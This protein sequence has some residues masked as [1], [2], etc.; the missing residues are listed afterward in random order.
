M[1]GG[2]RLLSR[3]DRGD[4]VIAPDV[5]DL[6]AA[7][8][9]AEI[10]FEAIYLGSYAS[11]ASRWGLPD[12]SLLTMSQLIDHARVICDRVDMPL[13]LDFED[14]GGNAVTCFR[15]VE[16]AVRAG[17]AAV[18][19]EDDRPG[20]GLGADAVVTRG[21][22]VQKIRAAC[23]ARAD[24][25]VLVI[26]RTGVVSAGGSVED[27]IERC[28]AFAEAGADLVTPSM[29][30]AAELTRFAAHVGVPV[31]GWA[32]GTATPA[33]LRAAGYS[34]AIYPMQTTIVAY[35]ANRTFLQGL[36]DEGRGIGL[37]EAITSA[38]EMMEMNGG[39]EN[40]ELAGRHRRADAG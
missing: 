25:D 26:G 10:G 32:F 29:L 22:A 5:H 35:E 27:A 21:E 19:I 9:A 14:G 2:A 20:K 8:L 15:N 16:A 40:V 18:Q 17:V 37:G 23:D 38:A 34:I 7:Q 33:E 13:I 1:G 28:A 3:I 36:H 4:C 31:A 24:S 39:D 6:V 30:P 11:A 12:Q